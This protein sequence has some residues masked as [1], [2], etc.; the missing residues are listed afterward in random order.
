LEYA[1]AGIRVNA[2]CPGAIHTTMTERLTS[3]SPDALERIATVIPAGRIGRPEEV[4]EAV[5]W[6]CSNAASFVTGHT[7]TVDGGYVAQ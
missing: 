3:R 7:L 1:K 4:A 5:L 2:V 6:L